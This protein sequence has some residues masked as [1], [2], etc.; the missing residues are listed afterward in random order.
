MA[1]KKVNVTEE[2]TT[3]EPSNTRNVRVEVLAGR[4]C[5]PLTGT[6]FSKGSVVDVIDLDSPDNVFVR[7]QIE[8][9]IFKILD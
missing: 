5:H 2:P 4:L 6:R 9:G 1:L 8:A 3:E 7:H